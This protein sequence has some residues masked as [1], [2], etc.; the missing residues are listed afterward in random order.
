MLGGENLYYLGF[1]LLH[2]GASLFYGT[3]GHYFLHVK[4]R[5]PT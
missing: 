1:S 4:K 5:P 2:F 3:I